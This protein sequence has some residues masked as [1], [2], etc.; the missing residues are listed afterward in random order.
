MEEAE[1]LLL[2]AAERRSTRST[3]FNATSSRSH[4]LVFVHANLP[5]TRSEPALR[6]AFVDLAGSERLPAE[7]GGAVADESR[8][9]NLSLS[10]LGS[11]IHA[12]R[13]RANHLPYRTCLL[14]RLL[15]P[16]FQGEWQSVTLCL[17][18]PR[19]PSCPGDAVLHGFCRQGKSCDPGC[20]IC[21]R[22]AAGASLGGGERFACCAAN[23]H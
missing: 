16:F 17:H 15:E 7:A 21:T 23:G 2:Q 19:A 1:A 22:G 3:C 6:L 13:H 20:R 12:L 11:V 18:Q 5:G 8:H 9:I 14:T 10:A 4:S